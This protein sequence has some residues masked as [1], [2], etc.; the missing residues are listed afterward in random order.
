MRRL[1]KFS[2]IIDGE[3]FVYLIIELDE[4]LDRIMVE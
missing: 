1:G 4:D 2:K 3:Y